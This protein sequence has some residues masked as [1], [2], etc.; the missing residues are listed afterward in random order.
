MRLN[1]SL[2]HCLVRCQIY[3][4]FFIGRFLC[5]Y[6]WFLVHL[7]IL[8]LLNTQ[9]P[10]VLGLAIKRPLGY[11]VVP[12]AIR[13]VFRHI[14]E[15]NICALIVSVISIAFLVTIKVIVVNVYVLNIT[16]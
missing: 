8:L 12:L 5:N 3:S 13:E 9:I 7:V 2:T 10:F 1:K 16:A 4:I 15:T 6:N 14:V 11:F